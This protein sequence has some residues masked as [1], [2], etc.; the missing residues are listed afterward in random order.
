M[1]V[2]KPELMWVDGRCYR[3]SANTEWS[4]ARNLSPYVED[5]CHL[6]YND[7][8]DEHCDSNIEIIPCGGSKFK[9]TFHVAK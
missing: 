8:E 9:H 6:D 7:Y 5:S 1:N 3:L 2:L 4:N